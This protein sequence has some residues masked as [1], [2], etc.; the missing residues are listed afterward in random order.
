MKMLIAAFLACLTSGT[1]AATYSLSLHGSGIHIPDCHEEIAQCGPGGPGPG[2]IS[3]SWV[4]SITAVVVPDGDG[5]W[6]GADLASFRLDANVGSFNALSQGIEG[7]VTVLGG[8]ITSVDLIVPF[9]PGDIV[10][11]FSGL[12]AF[13]EQPAQHHLGPTFAS[14]TLTPIPEPETY[15]LLGAGL[16]LLAMRIA[17]GG[18]T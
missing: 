17:R 5:T 8:Q 13:Y 3:F 14:G 9:L 6:S 7:S 10:A 15:A 12:A 11:S 1:L 16:L 4:G 18:R 2:E